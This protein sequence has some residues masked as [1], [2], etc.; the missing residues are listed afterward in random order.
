MI[1]PETE[2]R[3]INDNIGYGV[4]AR[5]L[6]R[7]GTITWIPDP[8]QKILKPEEVDSLPTV[9]QE[10]I[11]K[12]AYRSRDGQYIIEYDFGRFVNHSSKSN[13]LTTA[14]D[15]ELAIRDILPGEELTDDYGSL[16][17][18]APFECF[19]EPGTS[20]TLILPDDILRYHEEWDAYLNDAF[21]QFMHVEQPL[22]QHLSDELRE[23]TLAVA[24][25]EI[26][27]ESIL[28]CYY[29]QSNETPLRKLQR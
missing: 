22:M 23:T 16:N 24:K 27:M 4:F 28:A 7:K 13:C 18:E 11:Y 26:P 9:F 12:Y 10:V 5:K 29:D 25:G 19:P 17:I 1:H 3:Y 2:L 8:L 20:R 21:K 6:I 15:F 14:Y